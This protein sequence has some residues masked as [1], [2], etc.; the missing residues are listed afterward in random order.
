LKEITLANPGRIKPVDWLAVAAAAIL[1]AAFAVLDRASI[2]PPDKHL[3][4]A[5]GITAAF[6]LVGW[7][8]RGVDFSGA[9][10]GFAVALVLAARDLG[11]F[12][13][14]LTVFVVT[15][16]AT[17]TGG[18]RKRQLRGGE[19]GNTSDNR[20]DGQNG[21]HKRDDRRGRS[22]SQVMANLGVAG[23]IVALAPK[24]W[25]VLA[26]AALAEAAADTCSSEIGMAFPG[27]TVLITTWKAVPPGMDGGITILGTF[28]ALLAATLV[29]VPAKM[30]GLV[31]VHH[32][33]A[34]IYAGF[35]GSLVDSLLGALLERRGWL[36]NDT[37]NLLGTATAVGIVWVIA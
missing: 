3:L 9:V 29:A 27:K 31:S 7:L 30:L 23:L 33:T 34:V 36:N 17:R 35:L 20:H 13:V 18:D 19:Y 12:W 21:I 10:A 24:A 6:A 26:L 15:L 37:V 16:L 32:M 8:T 14:L 28:S 22:A 11:M 4:S 25:P 5:L 1:V 2:W